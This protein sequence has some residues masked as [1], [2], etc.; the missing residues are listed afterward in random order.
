MIPHVIENKLA[1]ISPEQTG[2]MNRSVDYR[3]D[4]YSLGIVLYEMA[5]GHVPFTCQR[6]H[7]DVSCPHCPQTRAALP[8]ER[9]K[10]PSRFPISL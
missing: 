8:G 6:P 3:T 2:R 7:G 5:T 4:L 10:S 1:Y 9:R